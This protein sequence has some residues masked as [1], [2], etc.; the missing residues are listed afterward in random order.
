MR[1]C[2]VFFVCAYC[3]FSVNSKA[4]LF[5]DAH[6]ET[7]TP[8]EAGLSR[9][10]LDALKELV[11]GRGCVVR[12]GY[13]VYSWGD[14]TRSSDVA[15][16]FKP[17]LSTLLL[18]A[19][20]DGL[21]NSVDELVADFEPRLKSLNNGKDASITWRHLASQTSG[22]GLAEPSGAAYSYND[23]ALALYYDTLTRKVFKTNGTEVLRERLAEP[24]QFEDAFT[25][26]AFRRP[27][28][29][30][31]LALSVRDF[32]RI[33]L[34][35]LRGGQ[36][37]DHQ[38]IQPEFIQMAIN[39]PIPAGT[40]LTSGREADM[41]PGQHSIGGTRNITRVGPGY[42]SFNWWLNRTNK[43]GQRLYVDAPPDTYVA[44]G[45]GGK[46]ALWI[47]P[48]LDLIVSWNDSPI[49]DHDQSPGDPNS[50]CNQAAR[51]MAEAASGLHARSRLTKLSI[52]D[53]QWH[54]ND[55]ITYRGSRAEGLLMNVRMVNAVFED[56]KRP[57]FD[58][59]ANA[60][61]FIARIPGYVT[62]GVRAFTLNLQG[63]M[64][65]YEGAVNS[66]FNPDGSLREA[67]LKRVGRVVEACDQ[68]GAAVI[69]GCFYQRQDQALRDADAVRAGVSNVV[70]WITN[71]GFAHVALEIANEFDHG[72]FDHRLLKTAEGQVELIQLAKQLAPELLV[73]TSGLGHG[74]IPD[75][76]AEVSDFILIHFNGTPLDKIPERVAAL[77]KFNKPVVCNEDDKSGADGAA[78]ARLSVA[79]GASWGL[80][81]Q[82]LN[83]HFPFTFN[84]AADDSLIYRTLN[85][86]TTQAAR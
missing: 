84:G 49:D 33:G 68:A 19:V 31:R 85:E 16:A 51:L 30:G 50:K 11:G 83:Q 59:E 3:V 32:A 70:S 66:A 26:N 54:F 7:R 36:W 71:R 40:P 82:R 17:V 62:S 6:W 39:S 42:Y 41:L 56:A 18:M 15:S 10:K 57:E 58:A 72:G 20:Q 73:A 52:Q 75:R 48:S 9:E 79:N 22:Y 53:G 77:K 21:L 69:L 64:P 80:M 67:Y 4:D 46:R 55:T 24:L 43:A 38:L 61:E 23:F 60:D 44:S 65:G 74:R 37:R 28:R 81:L 27:D 35:Y 25:F 13:M 2:L 76:V 5:P 29:D 34:L 86:L 8:D 63:G 78:A 45:H 12:H 47:F 1:R 14:Q